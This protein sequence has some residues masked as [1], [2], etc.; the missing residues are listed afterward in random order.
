ML[1]VLIICMLLFFQIKRNKY[2]L[3]FKRECGKII[4]AKVISWKAVPGRPTRYVIKVEYKKDNKQENKTFI[5]SGK[6]ARKYEHIQY[7]QIA[8]IPDSNKLFLDEED[9]R[10]QNRCYFVL[11]IFAAVFLLQ[12]L[13]IG[14]VT[15]FV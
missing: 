6:F 4:Q 3:K 1:V 15:I 11:L 10:A 8:F 9:W 12:L 7:I 14:F 5:S 2:N 13:L